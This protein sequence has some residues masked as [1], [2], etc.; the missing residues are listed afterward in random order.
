MV[1]CVVSIISGAAQTLFDRK[2]EDLKGDL[3]KRMK[4]VKNSQQRSK[5]CMIRKI[6]VVM[7]Y[8]NYDLNTNCNFDSQMMCSMIC[9]LSKLFYFY[10]YKPDF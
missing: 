6:F 1:E 8:G 10:G 2:M 3:N 4:A 7:L 9:C 5:K